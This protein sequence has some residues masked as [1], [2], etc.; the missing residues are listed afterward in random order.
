MSHVPISALIPC[1]N[2][3]DVIGPCL[4]SVAWADEIFICD[5]FSTD[6]TLEICRRYTDRI[7][8][9]EY[10]NSAAQKNWAIPQARHEW[11]LIVDTDER[12]SPELRREIERALRPDTPYAGFKIPRL[13]HVFDRPI[14]HGGNYPDYQLRL[15]RR[16]R[17]RYQERRVHAHLALQGGCGVFSAPLLHAGPAA[18]LRGLG[19]R[20]EERRRRAL[21]PPQPRGPPPGRLRGALRFHAR[22]P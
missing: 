17:G 2:S 7:V 3:A 18:A 6:A 5:S 20:A 12:V 19:G 14:R 15:F 8:Q 9:H 11:V 1:Y 22:I 4:E 10:V 16:D 21:P 13:N